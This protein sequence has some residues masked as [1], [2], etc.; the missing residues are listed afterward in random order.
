MVLWP[1]GALRGREKGKA[2]APGPSLWRLARWLAGGMAALSVLYLLGYA[3]V[4][5]NPDQVEFLYG[6]PPLLRVVEVLPLPIVALALG[7]LAF[8]VPVWGRRYWGVAGRVHYTL[9]AASGLA[10][11]WFLY[12]WNLLEELWF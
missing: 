5:G 8:T 3:L 4:V 10:F 11:I 7:A 6:D 2:R 9:V 1:V 12:Y